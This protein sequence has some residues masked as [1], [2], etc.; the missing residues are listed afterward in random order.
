[1]ARARA[2]RVG[3]RPA[4]T[5]D[6][7][8]RRAELWRRLG[9]AERA[10]GN[11]HAA[12]RA[13][14]RA[15]ST[16][17]ESDGALAAR[18][19]LV[20]LAAVA[21]PRRATPR[22]SRSSRRTRTSPT[23]SRGRA[24]S[25]RPTTPT[26]RAPRSSSRG[27]L[28]AAF[29]DDHADAHRRARRRR[30]LRRRAR[31]RRAPRA[32]RRRGRGAARRH[33]RAARRGRA[34]PLHRHAQ[35]ADRRRLR[36]RAPRLG[37]QRRRRRRDVPQIAKALGGPP[38]L[39]YQ[40]ARTGCE[41]ALVLASPPLVVHRPAARRV[42]R[43]HAGRRGPAPIS[44]CGSGSAG[45]SS[46]RARTACSRSAPDFDLLV[47]GLRHAFGPP[48][49]ARRGDRRR[50]RAPEG[51]A[52]AAAAPQDR[53]ARRGRD[54]RCRRAI[55]PRASAPPI[56]RACS[57]AVTSGSRSS[58]RAAPRPARHL[59]KLA[60]TQRYLAARRKLRVRR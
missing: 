29:D 9:D 18:R 59:V 42:A 38:T 8:P 31:R 49:P 19:G 57:R 17:P 11:E 43:A 16:A 37:D 13:Y 45:S 50:G 5:A 4:T 35:R 7:D 22:G 2:R 23:C 27:A 20:E 39:L 40:T 26:M 10:R 24:G 15:V 56:A 32:G 21:R 33:P 53:R 52:A 54:P 12:L 55:A 34:A 51:G 46:S 30:G 41:L 28:G 58:S 47:A 25:P 48:G 1:M 44:S 36:R 3:R 14:Q 6:G 60:S